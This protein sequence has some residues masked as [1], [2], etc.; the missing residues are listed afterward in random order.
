VDIPRELT[1]GFGATILGMLSVVQNEIDLLAL[2]GLL[3]DDVIA[4]RTAPAIIQDV[5]AH[6]STVF[7]T[8]TAKV[9]GDLILKGALFLANLHPATPPVPAPAPAPSPAPAPVPAV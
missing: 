8:P 7:K 2:A 1:A 5:I 4:G 9:V 3:K 6:D